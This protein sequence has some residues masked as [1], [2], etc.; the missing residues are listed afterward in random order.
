M[1]VGEYLGLVFIDVFIN[2]NLNTNLV[3]FKRIP[4]TSEGFFVA[5]PRKRYLPS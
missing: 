4:H 1:V 5:S 3:T 2:T